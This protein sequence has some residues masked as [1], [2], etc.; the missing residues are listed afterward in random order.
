[1]AYLGLFLMTSIIGLSLMFIKIALNYTNTID[2]LAHRFS[3]AFATI[4]L[5]WLFNI[6]KIPK[7]NKNKL[8]TLL[9]L[10]ISY[11]S[12]FFLLQAYGMEYSS[13]SEAG[14]IFATSPIITLIFAQIFLKEKTTLL[15]K[16]GIALSVIGVLYI[17]L[18]KGNF[19]GNIN[20]LQ[21]IVL[22]VFSMVAFTCYIILGKRST[23]K[24][25]AIEI[26]VW[27]TFIA[28]V[29]FNLVA[30]SSHLQAGKLDQF[31]AP[32]GNMD[33]VWSILYLGILS[34]VLTSFL[35]NYALPL[36]PA[37]Q[38]AVLNNLSPILSI[39]S[40]VL[41]LDERLYQYHI[42]GGV[43][44]IIGIVMTLVFRKR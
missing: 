39:L 4:M 42:L 40:G 2:L 8:K 1:M 43:F 15:Q 32:F 24:L 7:L 6:I 37:S 44:V 29:I 28:C 10:S 38:M 41:L 36:I 14:I 22:L 16:I 20:N 35:T 34:S 30:F 26:T 3:I 11:P 25:T 27:I 33:F 13:V 18:N 5:L 17:V 23:T 9:L 31:F 12:L 19:S 21:G